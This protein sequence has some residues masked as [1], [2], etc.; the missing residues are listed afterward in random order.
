MEEE[1]AVASFN[2][3]DHAS[4]T[5]IRDVPS[6]GTSY[7]SRNTVQELVELRKNEAFTCPRDLYAG[8][9]QRKQKC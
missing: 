2:R 9:D 1:A 8:N 4:T 7:V 5:D 6:N 3:E